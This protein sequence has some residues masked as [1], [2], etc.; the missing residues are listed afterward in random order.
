MAR[1][2]VDNVANNATTTTAVAGNANR[3]N[4][5]KKFTTEALRHPEKVLGCASLSILSE[6]LFSEKNGG[7]RRQHCSTAEDDFSRGKPKSHPE[8]GAK[9]CR[10]QQEELGQEPLSRLSLEVREAI[11]SDPMY[12]PRHDR[13]R[14]NIGVEYELLL[15]E[16][17]RSMGELFHCSMVNMRRNSPVFVSCVHTIRFSA[18]IILWSL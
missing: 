4:S 8:E 7:G 1:L 17:L 13:E 15:E 11:D 10:L 5:S 18:V 9:D 2:I 14:H 12:G 3:N 16:T 6:Y